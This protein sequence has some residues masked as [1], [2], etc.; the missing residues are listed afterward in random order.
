M[1]QGLEAVWRLMFVPAVQQERG[2][3]AASYIREVGEMDIEVL[4]R[5]SCFIWIKG[6]V[7]GNSN[8]L[9]VVDS[10]GSSQVLQGLI[11]HNCWLFIFSVLPL[12]SNVSIWLHLSV[13]FPHYIYTDMY[14]TNTCIPGK[15]GV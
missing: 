7:Q 10:A 14:Y 12:M 9:V 13:I 6:H 11:P 4:L 15:G 3:Q 8:G 5:T 2:K 1:Y